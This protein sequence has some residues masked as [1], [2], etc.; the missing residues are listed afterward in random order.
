M[1]KT[2]KQV[3]RKSIGFLLYYRILF[4]NFYIGFAFW[5]FKYHLSRIKRL[6]ARIYNRVLSF[7]KTLKYR[8]DMI[9]C[10]EKTVYFCPCCG[11]KFRSFISGG[12][13]DK[14]F[15]YDISRYEHTP[16]NVICPICN[17]L[18]RHRILALWCNKHKRILRKSN[19]LY[20]A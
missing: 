20:F 9:L 8:M 14:P 16:Q 15:R 3:C 2:I 18:P 13:I 11:M 4:Y 10:P 17:S 6:T 19:I 5:E 7:S 12:F 1:D